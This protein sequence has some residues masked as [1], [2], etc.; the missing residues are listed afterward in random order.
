[1]ATTPNYSWVMPDPTD[2]V[3]DLPADFEIF[4]DAV[5]ATVDGIDDRVTDLEVI[6]TEGDL[7]VGDASGDPVRVPVGTI[8]QVLASDGDTV[9]WITPAGGGGK[10]WVLINAGGTTLNAQNVT[11]SGLTG[12]N[13]YALIIA[14]AKVNS[15]NR[16]TISVAINNDNANNYDMA[17]TR[18]IPTTA[19]SKDNYSSVDLFPYYR[20]EITEKSDN[21]NSVIN[22]FLTISGAETTAPKVVQGFGSSSPATGNEQQ[23]N[24]FGG[25]W[26]NSATVSS[27]VIKSSSDQ[28][29]AGN[30]WLYGSVS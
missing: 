18:I 26:D 23:L 29:N 17:G 21:I 9:E 14:D 22:A 6:T 28:F 5:D 1:M 30:A 4:G 25:V 10:D 16:R 19:Y 2:F 3:T 13:E 11:I 8:G 20:I 27:I 24:W 7:I 15:A 12:Y